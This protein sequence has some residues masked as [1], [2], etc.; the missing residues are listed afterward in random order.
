VE[1]KDK[2]KAHAA[3]DDLRQAMEKAAVS[4][5]SDVYLLE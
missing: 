1:D 2:A 3:S 5:K 4:D